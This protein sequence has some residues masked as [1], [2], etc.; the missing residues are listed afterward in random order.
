MEST[1][2]WADFFS[3]FY[4]FIF[5]YPL[6]MAYVWMLAGTYYYFHW[7]RKDPKDRL[8]ELKSHPAVSVLVPCHNE[9]DNVVET[10]NYLMRN[11]YPDFE[12][13]AI[14]DGSTD[15]TG[16]ILDV[17]A[18]RFDKLRVIH[19][20]TNQGK[21]MAL[22][23]GALMSPNEFLVG[24]DGDTLLDTNAITWMVRHFDSPR[25]AAVT[26]NPRIRNRSTL[27]GKIQV[28]EFSSIVGMIKRAQRIYGRLFTVSGVIVAFRKSALHR[29]GYW[30]T[31][32][33]TED[34]DINWQ[35]QLD[36]WEVRYEPNALCW[37][38]MP[39][40]LKGLFKQRVRWA[41]GGSEVLIRYFKNMFDWR[42]RRMW[43]IFAEYFTSLVWA[44]SILA[45]ATVTILGQ[46]I[47]LPIYMQ[48]NV[49]VPSWN[50]LLLGFTCMFQFMVSLMID[51][52][53]ER[54]LGKYYYWMIWYPLIYWLITTIASVV[55]FP[56]AMFKQ[57]GER[58][59]WISPDRGLR[60][61]T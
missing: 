19:L 58:A 15:N 39:E 43:I 11:K 48:V 45:A 37:T 59:V 10:M 13:I 55:A 36:H 5:H 2:L 6:A 52:R 3:V 25:V 53:Y 12:V 21:A 60:A 56:K 27:L 18:R 9:G 16:K 49:I 57:R 14:N 4:S 42:M 29:V 34:I 38:L 17:L 41:Q 61:R 20:A 44:Y 24:I 1:S 26:G 46:F 50:G 23:M 47:E 32:M 40:T 35:L 31:D 7:E 8:P 33:V 30:S 54:G 22:R 51:S 28:G